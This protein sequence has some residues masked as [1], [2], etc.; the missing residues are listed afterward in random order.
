MKKLVFIFSIIFLFSNSVHGNIGIYLCEICLIL[1]GNNKKVID[2]TP[3]GLNNFRLQKMDSYIGYKNNT[4]IVK[5]Q[6]TENV[7]HNLNKFA[8]KKKEV[9]MKIDK[10][11]KKN[12]VFDLENMNFKTE[13]N[14]GLIFKF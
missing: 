4:M 5:E 11:R 9:Y 7:K 12:L 2:F 10:H 8:F 1:K 14:S 6:V 13:I 3:F